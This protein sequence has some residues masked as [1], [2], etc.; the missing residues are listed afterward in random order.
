MSTQECTYHD[1]LQK[2][3]VLALQLHLYV[4]YER[5]YRRHFFPFKQTHPKMYRQII[6]NPADISV[7]TVM[8]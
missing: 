1:L 2:E 4:I 6:L 5:H 7:I 3:T 8:A